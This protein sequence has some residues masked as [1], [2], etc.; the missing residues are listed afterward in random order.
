MP[1]IMFKPLIK[2]IKRHHLSRHSGISHLDEI[3]SIREALQSPLPMEIL[4][5]A[6]LWI[7]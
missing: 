4:V 2:L 6:V 7:S 5:L 3:S 1:G